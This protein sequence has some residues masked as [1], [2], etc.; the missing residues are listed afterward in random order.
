MEA[1][2]LE[3]E[4]FQEVRQPAAL[5]SHGRGKPEASGLALPAP[6]G[7]LEKLGLTF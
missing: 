6:G 4:A 2:E 1:G 3:E 7:F 5:S